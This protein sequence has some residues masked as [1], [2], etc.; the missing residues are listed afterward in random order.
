MSLSLRFLRKQ[1]ARPSMRAVQEGRRPCLPRVILGNRD[2]W[3]HAHVL[4]RFDDEPDEYRVVPAWTYPEE[5]RDAA[6]F[7]ARR[8]RSLM[9]ALAG[10]LGRLL[11][12]V[13]TRR[14]KVGWPTGE[15][16]TAAFV[17]KKH[18]RLVVA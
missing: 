2:P 15:L 11:A 5:Q 4:P 9:A 6:P 13:V 7:S 18:C 8:H 16:E 12:G 14:R 10:E 3:L 17:E 1:H